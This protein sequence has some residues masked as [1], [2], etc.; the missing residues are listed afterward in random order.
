MRW[1]GLGGDTLSSK[2]E[3]E[4]WEGMGRRFIL[5][6][7]F[8]VIRVIVISSR[9]SNFLS[10]GLRIAKIGLVDSV[11]LIG[12]MMGVKSMFWIDDL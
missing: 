4:E 3:E 5:G 9:V 12:E 6:V 2:E 11:E 10:R 7:F 1:V 8:G